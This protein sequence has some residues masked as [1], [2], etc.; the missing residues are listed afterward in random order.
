MTENTQK[1][2]NK[3][4]FEK[5][6]II[7]ALALFPAITVMVF[8]RHKLGFRMMKPI[9]LVI[10][11][12]IILVVSAVA[13]EVAKPF[14]SLFVIY[15]LAMLGLGLYQ[16]YLRWGDLAKGARWHTYSPGISYLEMLPIPP[17]FLIKRRVNRF[18]DPLACAIAGLLLALLSRALGAWV[19][20]SALA[21]FIYEQALY[22]RMLE[23][24]LDILDGLV[25]AEVQ[26][27]VAQHYEG[28]QADQQQMQLEQTAGIP[29]GVAP[30]IHRQVELRKAKRA[31]PPDNLLS[32]TPQVQALERT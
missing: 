10:M 15:A 32:E 3:T 8:I 2:E 22:E 20:F 24:D 11:T 14:A 1:F 21:L 16:R 25:A 29:T 18:L 27:E 6:K 30:D 12:A 17:F 13:G 7:Q 5:A 9:W 26:S 4:L 28:P 23:Q 19:V 31:A